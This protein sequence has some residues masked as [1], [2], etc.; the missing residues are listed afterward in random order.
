MKPI[1]LEDL[2]T[3]FSTPT[4]SFL[5]GDKS[6]SLESFT[7]TDHELI[8]V[9]VS[10]AQLEYVFS[11]YID[12]LRITVDKNI[13]LIKDVEEDKKACRFSVYNLVPA[14]L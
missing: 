6:I 9:F 2:E 1:Y 12:D 13:V 8:L 7:I 10:T 5:D 3:I 11:F 4:E 14:E